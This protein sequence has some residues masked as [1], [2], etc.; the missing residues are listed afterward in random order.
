MGQGPMVLP[1]YPIPMERTQMIDSK[2]LP[3][4]QYN[5]FQSLCLGGQLNPHGNPW[6]K[7]NP[8]SEPAGYWITNLAACSL[9]PRVEICHCVDWIPSQTTIAVVVYLSSQGWYDKRKEQPLEQP[10]IVSCSCDTN[11]NACVISFVIS[12]PAI[13]RA[14]GFVHHTLPKQQPGH[15][16]IPHMTVNYVDL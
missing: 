1:R 12:N 13:V 8:N 6:C 5:R 14:V 7:H 9:N 3:Q 11:R 10:P 4:S 15:Y 16:I 2:L